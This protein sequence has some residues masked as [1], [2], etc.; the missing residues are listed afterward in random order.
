MVFAAG[1]EPS[2]SFFRPRR[3]AQSHS[4]DRADQDEGT[5]GQPVRT[6]GDGPGTGNRRSAP[7]GDRRLDDSWD[8]GGLERAHVATMPPASYIGLAQGEPMR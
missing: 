8:A 2:A 4:D 7:R 5:G 3:A 1:G 6:E